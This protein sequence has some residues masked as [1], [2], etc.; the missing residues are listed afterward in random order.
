[1]H[2]APISGLRIRPEY[3]LIDGNRYTPARLSPA[4]R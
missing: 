3:L 2:R 4:R 1:M